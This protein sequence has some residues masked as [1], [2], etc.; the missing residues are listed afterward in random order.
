MP[1][2]WKNTGQVVSQ[3]I[4]IVAVSIMFMVLVLGFLASIAAHNIFAIVVM[5][6]VVAFVGFVL[7]GAVGGLRGM[8][9]IKRVEITDDGWLTVVAADG[10]HTHPLSA[11]DM[12]YR[13]TVVHERYNA[14][15]RAT[16]VH[17]YVTMK[18]PDCTYTVD[19]YDKDFGKLTDFLK[20]FGKDVKPC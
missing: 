15:Y 8:T 7:V 19:L 20:A 13:K 9:R 5:G 18:C 17:Y 3:I 10:E 12:C 2:V 1:W 11:V 16:W 4:A 14:R 6:T